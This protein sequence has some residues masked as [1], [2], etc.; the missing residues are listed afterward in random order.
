MLTT[1]GHRNSYAY[2]LILFKTRTQTKILNQY[3]L[4]FV[5][6]INCLQTFT[7]NSRIP[8]I[9][10]FSYWYVV[11]RKWYENRS[12]SH[13]ICFFFIYIFTFKLITLQGLLWLNGYRYRLWAW[14]LK[15]EKSFFSE[16]SWN[17]TFFFHSY[18]LQYMS[19]GIFIE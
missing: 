11:G 19:V 10:S 18:L 13:C 7:L 9:F 8:E 4:L 3:M 15:M 5:M 14:R 6:Y 1:I 16:R 17:P 12:S 2:K